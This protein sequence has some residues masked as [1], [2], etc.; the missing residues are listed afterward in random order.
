MLARLQ[1]HLHPRLHIARV[2]VRPGQHT[3]CLQT[4]YVSSNPGVNVNGAGDRLFRA[5][6]DHDPTTTA[7]VAA[8]RTFRYGDLLRDVQHGRGIV[9]QQ[10]RNRVHGKTETGLKGRRVAFLMENNY[11]YVG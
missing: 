7:V 3:Q 9:S 11:D 5:L 4:R 6:R 8:S 1:L 10:N 2:G